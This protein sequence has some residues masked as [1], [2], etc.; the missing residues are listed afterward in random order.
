MQGFQANAWM[1][2]HDCCGQH[3]NCVWELIEPMASNANRS[4]ANPSILG[5]QAASQDVTL[6]A[7]KSNVQPQ[8][9]QTQH[10]GALSLQSALPLEH[11]R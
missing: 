4:R 10:L 8:C 11:R 5:G 6:D 2:V 3:L 1:R 9:M 7:V